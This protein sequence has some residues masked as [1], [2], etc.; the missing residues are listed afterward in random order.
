MNFQL[1]TFKLSKICKKSAAIVEAATEGVNELSTFT[2][3]TFN[4]QTFNFQTF[5]FQRFA[6]KSAAIVEAATEG[7][8]EQ[9]V[10]LP[11]LEQVVLALLVV[12][13]RPE[14]NLG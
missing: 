13:P 7:V 1:S 12:H 6:K 3:Q 4:F 2:F 5:N 9:A 11:G 8:D 10:G 14:K